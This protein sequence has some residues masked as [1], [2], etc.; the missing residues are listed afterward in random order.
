MGY[1]GRLEQDKGVWEALYSCEKLK[2]KWAVQLTIIGYGSCYDE[3][4][5]YINSHQLSDC[6]RIIPG[7]PQKA[8]GAFYR[9]MDLFLFSSRT[10]ES[11]GLTGIEAMACGVPVIGSNIG[12][13][14]T[15][16][17][18]KENGYLVTPA[19]VA[20]MVHC[21]EQYQ[22][23]SPV[24]KKDMRN[25]CLKTSRN[26]MTP[27]VMQKLSSDLMTVLRWTIYS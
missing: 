11:L 16:V 14:A 12:G 8:L 6:V 25:C 23:L 26:Y 5:R 21:I 15:Y 24:E 17:R 1:V 22:A 4:Q 13:I 20:E 3:L 9:N 19:N 7:V 27:Y 2:D 18:D 10:G